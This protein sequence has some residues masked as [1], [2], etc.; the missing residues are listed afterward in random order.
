MARKPRQFTPDFKAQVVLDLL[1]TGKSLSQASR[2]L[3]IKDSVLSRWR[4]E[5]IER[6]PQLFESGCGPDSRDAKITEMERTLGRM[7][8]E[9]EMSKKVSRLIG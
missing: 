6:A 3:G 2:E 5:F 9:L 8:L 4:S 1:V 7:T